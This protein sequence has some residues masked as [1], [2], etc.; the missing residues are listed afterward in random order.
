MATEAQNHPGKQTQSNPIS[1]NHDNLGRIISA[2]IFRLKL[3]WYGASKKGKP[4]RLELAK[5]LILA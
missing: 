1:L 4:E 3:V 2:R 5:I